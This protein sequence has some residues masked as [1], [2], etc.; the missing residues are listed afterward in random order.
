MCSH[1]KFSEDGVIHDIYDIE[2]A[3]AA[4]R[5]VG[6]RAARQAAHTALSSTVPAFDHGAWSQSTCTICLPYAIAID[7][8]S[9]SQY[10]CTVG[11]A[12]GRGLSCDVCRFRLSL[13]T[14]AHGQHSSNVGIPKAYH[15]T[16]ALQLC[17]RKRSQLFPLTALPKRTAV[18]V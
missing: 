13:R 7:A 5:S 10:S 1:P 17:T 16:T 6:R 14:G 2:T 9:S 4:P 3:G 8:P 15:G 12:C 11:T 18:F